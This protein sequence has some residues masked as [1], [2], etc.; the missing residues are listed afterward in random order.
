MLEADGYTIGFSEGIFK[1]VSLLDKP[2]HHDPHEAI[3][4]IVKKGRKDFDLKF[5]P[6]ENPFV[7]AIQHNN[8]FKVTI[9]NVNIVF[10][11]AH[12]Q[13]KDTV[14]VFLWEELDAQ[15]PDGQNK[16]KTKWYNLPR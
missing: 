4:A 2:I 3:K 14:F 16:L 13:E 5:V 15:I 9:G 7:E 8:I 12:Y 11:A 10:T 1:M 6:S